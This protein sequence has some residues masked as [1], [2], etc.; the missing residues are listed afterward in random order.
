MG[1]ALAPGTAE[2]GLEQRVEPAV[3]RL[4]AH[5]GWLLVLDDLTG[6]VD[7]TQ[8]LERVRTG[9]V[10]I[11]SR[12]AGGWHGT[13]VAVDVLPPAEAVELLDRTVRDQWPDAVLADAE[14]LCAEPGRL[15]LA[16]EQ[17]AAYPAQSRITPNAYLDLL[18]RY[19]ARVFTATAE[20]G[21]AQR[22]AARVWHVTL[23]RLADTPPAGDL[24]RHLLGDDDPDV[25]HSL[26]R[27]AAYSM[28]TLTAD[29]IGVHRLVQAV[30]L[31]EATLAD[32]ERVLGSD[33]PTTRVIRSNLEITNVR[34]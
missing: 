9:T 5:D 29:A 4:A 25:V 28:V 17:T 14:R 34:G 10:L 21:D 13:T 27:P 11:T 32:A 15:P 23:D 1:V 2:L 20:G 31:H 30:A 8:L 24:L 33:H 16:V 3:R 19:P 6:P 26:G 22:I 7:A 12:Q 18:R